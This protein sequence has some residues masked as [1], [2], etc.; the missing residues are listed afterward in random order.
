ME[1]LG[2]ECDGGTSLSVTPPGK[3][4]AVLKPTAL[5]NTVIGPQPCTRRKRSQCSDESDTQNC[6]NGDG[7]WVRAFPYPRA[8]LWVV[9]QEQQGSHL[10]MG[11]N[12]ADVNFEI[13]SQ[14]VFLREP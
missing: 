8:G 2:W 5:S 11:L 13:W 12:L 3:V 10:P 1:S 9:P 4:M 6:P 14:D 7:K